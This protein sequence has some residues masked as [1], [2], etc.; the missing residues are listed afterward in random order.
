MLSVNRKIILDAAAFKK[1]FND[2][3]EFN[4]AVKAGGELVFAPVIEEKAEDKDE[5][6]T[7]KTE[8]KK[9]DSEKKIEK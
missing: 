4:K 9:E 7:D 6:K 8:E 3:K 5:E 1:A 2:A